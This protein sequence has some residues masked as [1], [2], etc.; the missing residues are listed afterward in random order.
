MNVRSSQGSLFRQVNQGI[1]LT[2][3]RVARAQQQLSSGKRILAP[4][5]DPVGASYALSLRRQISNIDSHLGAIERSRPVLTAASAA[6]QESTNVVTE[7]RALILQGMNG[8]L[9]QADREAVAD[10]LEFAYQSLLELGNSRFQDRF[11]F[12]G[13]D[14]DT[15]PF[16]SEVSGGS[17][18]VVYGGNSRSQEVAVARNVTIDLN[19]TGT[20]AFGKLEYS[21]T[22]YSGITGVQTGSSA[23]SGT[24]YGR[25]ILRNDTTTGVPG[26]G[27]ALVQTGDTILGDHDLVID[28]AA[29]TIQLG[30]GTAQPIPTP[31][32]SDFVVR[33]A[34]GSEVHLDLTG[35]TGGDATSTLTGEGSI[36]ID[37]TNYQPIDFTAT[38]VELIDSATGNVLHVNTTE[39]SRAGAELVKF[40]GATNLFDT[41]LGAAQDLRNGGNLNQPELVNRLEHR[42]TELDRSFND[43][44][45]A[46]GDLGSRLARFDTIENSQ[47][48]RQI[49][50]EGILSTVEDADLTETVLEMSRAEQTLE[51]A[52]ATGAR[53]IQ[54][55]LLNFLR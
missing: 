35:Y 31:L 42:L 12:G 40:S 15:E 28:G 44:Q 23:D 34:D 5:D 48:E 21:G 29:G 50:F 22:A 16:T 3:A 19:T 39:V 51:M 55:S 32:P 53:I 10:Q 46:G 4:S 54:Q 6:V 11:L 52:Q 7:A 9:S 30:D 8:T 36:S 18:R 49:S 45:I 37:G 24:G 14:I 13:T 47:L 20:D 25:L 43:L 2:L 38:D 26:A 33:D 17:E 41:I 1:Q 27:V